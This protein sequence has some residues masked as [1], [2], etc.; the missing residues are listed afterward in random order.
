[1]LDLRP[2]DC[3]GVTVKPTRLPYVGSVSGVWASP[4]PYFAVTG[5]ASSVNRE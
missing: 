2:N 4:L 1:M 3:V 5:T